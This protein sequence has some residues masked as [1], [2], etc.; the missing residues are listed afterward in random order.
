M[1]LLTA[2]NVSYAPLRLPGV[3][4]AYHCTIVGIDLTAV[5]ALKLYPEV[6][7]IGHIEVFTDTVFVS[8]FSEIFGRRTL[9]Q[10][11]LAEAEVRLTLQYLRQRRHVE[12]G[13][14][15]SARRSHRSAME[16]HP[17]RH[18]RTFL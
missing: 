16:K 11:R 15:H 9:P 8:G 18:S 14:L 13:P 2:P 12:S 5:A 17:V 10:I 1:H 3:A 4:H 6:L 7:P